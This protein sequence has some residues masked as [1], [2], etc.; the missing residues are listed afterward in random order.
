MSTDD[1]GYTVFYLD[2]AAHGCFIVM[3]HDI[4]DVLRYAE[5]REWRVKEV[6][7]QDIYRGVINLTDK[8]GE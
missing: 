2:T 7:S 3:A 1:K 8:G 5:S 4:G 6:R